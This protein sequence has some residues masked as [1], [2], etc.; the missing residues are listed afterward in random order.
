MITKKKDK[1]KKVKYQ[2]VRHCKD[3]DEYMKEEKG[4]KDEKTN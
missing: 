1:F 3:L 4:N 2:S